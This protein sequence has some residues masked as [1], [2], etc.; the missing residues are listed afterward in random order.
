MT[1][2]TLTRMQNNLSR[3]NERPASCGASLGRSAVLGATRLGVPSGE[4]ESLVIKAVCVVSE[5]LERGSVGLDKTI[6]DELRSGFGNL[7]ASLTD[8]ARIADKVSCDTWVP[9][10]NALTEQVVKDLTDAAAK[11]TE[12][13]LSL[14]AVIDQL[15][16]DIAPTHLSHLSK[17]DGVSDRIEKEST[18]AISRIRRDSEFFERASSLDRTFN[19]LVDVIMK[20][21]ETAGSDALDIHQYTEIKSL[22]ESSAQNIISLDPL[23]ISP[24]A[25]RAAREALVEMLKEL[26]LSN[27]V[28]KEVVTQFRAAISASSGLHFDM[29]SELQDR[30]RPA[31]SKIDLGN[32]GIVELNFNG[33]SGE[34]SAIIT[35]K[36]VSLRAT[37]SWEKPENP[38]EF[39]GKIETLKASFGE[40]VGSS[41]ALSRVAS[42]VAQSTGQASPRILEVEDGFKSLIGSPENG[43][44][45]YASK[46]APEKAYNTADFT[47]GVREVRYTVGGGDFDWRV[48]EIVRD[49]FGMRRL[50]LSDQRQKTKMT[51]TLGQG[52]L[53]DDVISNLTKTIEVSMKD[54]PLRRTPDS[55]GHRT[56]GNLVSILLSPDEK[57]KHGL[58][59][60]KLISLNG[61]V[62]RGLSIQ[63]ASAV[64]GYAI[65]NCMVRE[66]S[67]VLVGAA[68][69]RGV[70]ISHSDI[71]LSL[72]GS[73]IVDG[74]RFGSAV[75]LKGRCTGGSRIKNS[76]FDTPPDSLS[77]GG[78]WYGNSCPR[79][80]FGLSLSEL[81]LTRDLPRP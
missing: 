80:L 51:F 17:I 19:E 72:G 43:A 12:H 22:C 40:L 38:I 63:S 49:K 78:D 7:G 15:G 64:N 41:D 20:T 33:S 5:A 53:T 45:G 21:F 48:I 27:S 67:L 35:S 57:K 25:I 79:R 24:S 42:L 44:G 59:D 11:F 47:K 10:D 30:Y 31:D 46:V 14:S 18:E 3:G 6:Y 77:A 23:T 26:E 4:R 32:S 73:G 16:T 8:Y 1:A 37:Y 74:C 50:S 81:G 66:S 56:P 60:V 76:F 39:M 65:T 69:L 54:L 61:G 52:T 58:S 29:L 70:T 9:K 2:S 75:T 13:R 55:T 34:Y 36:E 68:E 62:H 28:Q 71:D